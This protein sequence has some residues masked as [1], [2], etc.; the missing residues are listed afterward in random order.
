MIK[1]PQKN[2]LGQEGGKVWSGNLVRP[3]YFNHSVSAQ[4]DLSESRGGGVKI[5]IKKIKNGE[6]KS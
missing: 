1:A 6:K 5:K 3:R 4:S 2:E